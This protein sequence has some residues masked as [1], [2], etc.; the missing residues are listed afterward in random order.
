MRRHFTLPRLAFCVHRSLQRSSD[1]F[2][3]YY[4]TLF[5]TLATCEIVQRNVFATFERCD[6]VLSHILCGSFWSLCNNLFKLRR[7]ILLI[8]LAFR[9]CLLPFY[10]FLSFFYSLQLP[11]LDWRSTPTIR[12]KTAIAE[13][14]AMQSSMRLGDHLIFFEVR[15]SIFIIFRFHYFTL[16]GQRVGQKFRFIVVRNSKVFLFSKAAI[17]FFIFS[18]QHHQIIS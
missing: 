7:L 10:W 3:N 18:H 17:S 4:K 8:Y 1:S 6:S 15:F 9:I 12:M 11:G 14:I 16:V 13:W 2:K 5:S